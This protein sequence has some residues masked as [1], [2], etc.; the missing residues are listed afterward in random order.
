MPAISFDLDTEHLA[1]EYERVSAER[2]FQVGKR[3]IEQLRIRAGENVLDIGA[4]TGLLAEYAAGLVGPDGSVIGIDPLPLRIDIASRRNCPNLAFRVGN[5]NDLSEFSENH[6]DA[7]Y[8]NAVFHWLP[9]KREPLRQIIW[10]LK[11]GGRLGISTGARGNSNLLHSVRRRVLERAP[12]NR[13]PQVSGP[14]AHRVSAEELS[15]L[16]TAAGF[17]IGKLETRLRARPEQSP[18]ELIQ[19]SEASS[20][21]N[22][23]GHLPGEL[24]LMARYEIKRELAKAGGP[25][26]TVRGITAIAIK[27]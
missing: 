7:A 25:P 20:F 27:P 6:F 24:R 16:L 2:Q 12:Y 9:E 4:G 17:V 18:E 23:L 14:V 8:M 13:Y 11:S 19:F 15:D 5:A 26:T 21:G 10:V 1:R 3:L 22:F